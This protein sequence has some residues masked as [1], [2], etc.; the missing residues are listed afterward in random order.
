MIALPWGRKERVAH[1]PELDKEIADARAN[2]R[3][4]AQVIS[5]GSRVLQTMAGM[6]SLMAT[7][8]RIPDDR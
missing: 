6:M 3:Q 1:T 5:S 4:S 8:E 2:L 7:A